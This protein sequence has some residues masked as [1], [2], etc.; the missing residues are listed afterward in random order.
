MNNLSYKQTHVVYQNFKLGSHKPSIAGLISK[1]NV[2]KGAFFL[3]F[4]VFVFLKRI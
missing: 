2:K 3:F 4:C 1:N